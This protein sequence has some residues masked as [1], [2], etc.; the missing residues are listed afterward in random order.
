MAFKKGQNPNHPKKGSS[1]KVD[2]I[3]DLNAISRI[4]RSLIQSDN[5]RDHCLFTLG[6]NTGWRANE[7]LSINIGQ[8]R[9]IRDN[10]QISLKESKTKKYRVTPINNVAH[11]AIEFWL[12]HYDQNQ[13]EDAPLFPSLRSGA[14][15]VPT[16]CNLVK[17]WC[18]MADVAGH[19]G[20]HSLRKTW[21]YHQRVT[22][23]APLSVLVKAY[24]HSSERQTLDY[25]GIQPSE[26]EDLYKNEL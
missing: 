14:I 5:L 23:E 6:I 2:P 19:F 18:I 3:R 24:G 22:F 4:K 20:S 12:A 15:S 1:I 7:L 10:R 8:A 21:G 17:H 26:I 16:L 11:R 9:S 25:L 13:R